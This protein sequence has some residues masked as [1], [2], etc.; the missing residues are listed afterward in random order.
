MARRRLLPRTSLSPQHPQHRVR[1]T[2][3]SPRRAR[4]HPSQGSWQACRR[5]RPHR[6]C[7]R[8]RCRSR[9]PRRR[10][11]PRPRLR[12]LLRWSRR[13]GGRSAPHPRP[14]RAAHP[15][16]DI[17]L[18]SSRPAPPRRPWTLRH[19]VVRSLSPLHRRLRLCARCPC[20]RRRRASPPDRRR[21]LHRGRSPRI[22]RLGPR[23]VGQPSHSRVTTYRPALAPLS[24][25][26]WRPPR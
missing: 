13:P 1:R 16:P 22:R 6:W 24:R 21:C 17:R 14:R 20:R 10:L 8:R 9:T 12:P 18:G 25:L 11:R 3:R 19:R 5:D 7:V 4:R 26:G 15:L 23:R 2:A